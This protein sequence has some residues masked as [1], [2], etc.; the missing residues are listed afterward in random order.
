MIGYS[1]FFC[2]S[3]FIRIVGRLCG[4]TISSLLV[5]LNAFLDICE[6]SKKSILYIGDFSIYNLGTFGTVD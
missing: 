5:F 3:I 2:R 6:G 4:L 1:C